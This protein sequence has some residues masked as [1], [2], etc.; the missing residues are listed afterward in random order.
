[1]GRSSASSCRPT[2]R[3]ADS[4]VAAST[5]ASSARKAA[6]AIADDSSF[7]DWGFIEL[8][9]EGQYAQASVEAK[10]ARVGWPGAS[11]APAPCH[12]DCPPSWGARTARLASS[13]RKKSTSCAYS[14]WTTPQEKTPESS[15]A[16]SSQSSPGV[17][18]EVPRPG[19]MCTVI[20]AGTRLQLK[21]LAFRAERTWPCSFGVPPSNT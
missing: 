18:L 7:L 13:S 4:Y 14:C 16:E 3:G 9:A 1:M 15:R 5:C 11:G 19:A 6:G 2:P 20:W 21:A 8:R 12:Q 17:A 10:A